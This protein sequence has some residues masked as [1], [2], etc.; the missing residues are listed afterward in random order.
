MMEF[1]VNKRTAREWISAFTSKTEHRVNGL[2]ES[3]MVDVM[4]MS[5]E[6]AYIYLRCLADQAKDSASR[7]E[8]TA[9]GAHGLIFAASQAL[10]L[11][12]PPSIEPPSDTVN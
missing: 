2:P 4:D 5:T 11:A 7:T 6:L 12:D 1:L 3:E 9:A 10:L 8:V